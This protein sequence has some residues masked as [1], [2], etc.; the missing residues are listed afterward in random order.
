MITTEANTSK[1]K[2]TSWG[3]NSRDFSE[4]VKDSQGSVDTHRYNKG[5]GTS[6][7]ANSLEGN[8]FPFEEK[9]PRRE[10]WN[11]HRE[12]HM[13]DFVYW[14][15][16]GGHVDDQARVSTDKQP[17]VTTVIIIRLL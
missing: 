16:I 13:E 14:D 5:K 7:S 10:K 4:D 2:E 1:R 3:E 9:P 6:H 8:S 15:T 12:D 17:K 11:V